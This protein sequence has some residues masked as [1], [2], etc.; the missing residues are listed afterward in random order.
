VRLLSPLHHAPPLA[1]LAGKPDAAQFVAEKPLLGLLAVEL[2]DS[3]GD[4]G[5]I[6]QNRGF[7]SIICS[8]VE[9]CVDSK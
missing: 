1:V 7:V 5:F 2:V 6:L 8:P 4:N 3:T 9:K